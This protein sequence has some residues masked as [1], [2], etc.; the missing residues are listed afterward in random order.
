VRLEDPG[1]PDTS[2]LE[3]LLPGLQRM[4]DLGF[5]HCGLSSESVRL[6]QDLSADA[7]REDHGL[8]CDLRLLKHDDGAPH[9]VPALSGIQRAQMN[10]CTIIALLADIARG[11]RAAHQRRHAAEAAV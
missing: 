3:L 9:A 1:R 2:L 7:A 10:E 5:V 6:A 8:V 4:A 11:R